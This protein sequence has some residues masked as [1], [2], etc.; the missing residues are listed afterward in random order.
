MI[1]GQHVVD[2]CAVLEPGA[3]VVALGHSAGADEHFPYGA[4]IADPATSGCSITS[5]FL[6]LE[7]DV[8]DEMAYFAADE[9]L[10]S[11]D[12]ETC[13][14]AELATWVEQGGPRP[15]GRVV[16]RVD[17]AESLN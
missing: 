9:Q 14:W 3:T 4:F 12:N 1:G 10:Q 7:P 16:F 11:G 13:A 5:F 6:E 15:S 2:T 17:H 8:A